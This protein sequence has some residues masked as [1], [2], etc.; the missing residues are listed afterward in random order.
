MKNILMLTYNLAD[1]CS[2]YRAAGIVKDLEKKDSDL[3]FT[4]VEWDK[5]DTTW[6]VTGFDLVIMQRAFCKQAQVL[7][8][9]LK[10]C[11]IPL[12]VDWDDDLFHLN[13]ENP[14]YD[15]YS[16]P[17]LIESMKTI[18]GLADIVTI[19][20]EYLRQVLVELNPR[21]EIIPNAFNDRLFKRPDI[22]SQRTNQVCWRG[23]SAHTA[24][25]MAYSE[26]VSQLMDDYPD[27]GFLF[28]G[29]NPWFIKKPNRGYEG[30]R[31]LVIY[32]KRLIEMAPSAVHIPL[33]DNIF[34]RCRSNVA[35]LEA[36]YAGAVTIC[37]DWWEAPGALQY[38]NTQEYFQ[39]L[40][41]VL[42]GRADKVK[43]NNIAWEYIQD[44][45]LLSKV[46]I[47][48]LEIINELI[49]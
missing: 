2:F 44:C 15:L 3:R 19:P 36:T 21:I 10:E 49:S 4:F 12:W 6:L 33:L 14:A 32:H 35:Y 30:M 34:N 27:W 28:L 39:A 42:S 37:P 7:A 41:E 40:D 47:K 38:T 46:N 9:Y 23:P 8:H 16:D 18:L 24:D 48:R 5:F 13:E 11:R 20:T 31:D 1:S 45:R 22:L 26:Q 29:F 43:Q 25:L 17:S